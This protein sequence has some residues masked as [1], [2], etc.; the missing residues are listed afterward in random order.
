MIESPNNLKLTESTDPG[1]DALLDETLRPE[2]APEGLTARIVAATA[3]DLPRAQRWRGIGGPGGVLRFAAVVAMA[4]GLG[5]AMWSASTP[6]DP[7]P[8][9]VAVDTPEATPSLDDLE[10]RLAQ[11]AAVSAS[12]SD[13]SGWLDDQ[14]EL[15]G[16]RVDMVQTAEAWPDEDQ[17]IDAAGTRYELDQLVDEMSLMF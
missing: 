2:P 9:A 16:L 15:V 10:G 1:L 7:S 3:D 14:I 6:R 11:L 17:A 4:A 13:D 12:A 8:P 5:V